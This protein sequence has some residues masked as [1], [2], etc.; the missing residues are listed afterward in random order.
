[1]QA[2]NLIKETSPY[3]LQHAYNPV[4]WYAWGEEALKKAKD[5]NKPIFLS[6]GY[7]ACH[8]CHVMAHESFE[9]EDIA[10]IMN[11]N[12]VNI[13]VDREERPDIDDIYQKVCQLVTGSGGWP[14][15][16]FLTPDQKPFYVGTYFPVLDSYGKP[17]FGSLLHQIAQAYKE[18]PSDVEA[19][20]NNFMNVLQ[21]TESN[22][23]K[24]KIDKLILDEAAINL[25]QM[26]DLIN[27]GFGNA[28]KFP[29]AANLSYMLRYSKLSGISKFQEFVF[30]TLTKMANGGIYDQIGGGFHRYSTDSR[31]LVPHFEKMLYDNALLPVVYAE[32]YQITKDPKYLAVVNQTLHYILR[33]M[34]SPEGGF[35]SAQDADSEGEEGKYYVWK[36]NQIQ[37]IIGEDADVFCLYYDVTDGGNFEGY[38]IL[39]NNIRTSTIAFQFGKT[40]NVVNDIIKHSSEKLFAERLKRIAPGKDEKILTSWNGLMV[41][42]FVKGYR[43]SGQES[44]LHAAK[45]CIKFIEEKLTTNG[46]LL[47]TYKDGQAKL[48]A[49]LDD[50]AY[51]VN[52]LLDVFEVDPSAKYIQLA[53]KHANY[54]IEHFWDPKENN[55]FFTSDDHEKLIIRTKNIYDLSLPSGNSIAAHAFLK[56]YHF[57]QDKKFLDISIKIMES[58]S[59]M[60]AENPFG[61]GQLLNTIYLYIQKPIE[62]TL[63]NTNNGEIYDGLTK[64]FIPESILVIISKEEY[65]N[66]LKKYHYFSG[67]E[68][69]KNKTTVYICKDFTCSLPLHSMSEIEKLL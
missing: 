67:K 1:M 5:E 45:N 26:G 9:N 68:F 52:A 6:I 8:W 2:N 15:S 29:N 27:G 58:L 37:K 53:L 57:T 41:S 20:A 21:K 33:E 69:D 36:K 61:F 18:K 4:K 14:L 40:E 49:Y 56:L 30:K 44:F 50:Y 59:V 31:W 39:N 64:K 12:F 54:L 25:L 13:K 19:A 55:F 66:E 38:N 34:T 7:S 22:I 23:T 63:L 46:N 42:A 48:K 3:L 35:Y 11:E 60:A 16:V 62:I 17:G 10:Q 65:L 43:I 28:P 24:S 47:R 32:A 51:F